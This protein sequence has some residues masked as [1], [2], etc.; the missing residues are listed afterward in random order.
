VT[1]SKLYSIIATVKFVKNNK[2]ELMK[3]VSAYEHILNTLKKAVN[4]YENDE[5]EADQPDEE[6]SNTEKDPVDTDTPKRVYSK[7]WSPRQYSDKES[8]AIREH[9]NNG[10]SPREAER[11]AGAHNDATNWQDALKSGVNPSMPSDKMMGHLKD[12]AKEYLETIR[13]HELANA[14][15][16]KNPMKYASGQMEQVHKERT[17]D[18]S[19]AYDDFLESDTLKDLSPRDRHKAVQEW[20]GKWKEANPDYEKGL[21]AVSQ[22]QSKFADAAKNIEQKNKEISDHIGRGGA[23]EVPEMSAQEAMQHLGGGK[24]EE[25]YTGGSI[26]KDPTA[27]FAAKNPKLAELLRPEQHDRMKRVDSAAA[28]QGKVRTRKAGTAPQ[29]Q[30]KLAPISDEPEE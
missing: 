18:Y 8:A 27:A 3:N 19:Q 2:E 15:E 23:S 22:V 25:G 29:E 26:I 28:Q 1:T 11:L 20:K 10:Y 6:D 4:D 14:D 30:P 17:K 13:S 7:D 9:I 24:A 16:M 12:L 21:E 5:P